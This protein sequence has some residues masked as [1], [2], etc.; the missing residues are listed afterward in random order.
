MATK[1]R[2]KRL[3]NFSLK[4]IHDVTLQDFHSFLQIFSCLPLKVNRQFNTIWFY[5]SLRKNFFYFVFIS[6]VF[7]FFS[8]INILSTGIFLLVFSLIACRYFD[9]CCKI[10]LSHRKN[11]RKFC[12]FLLFSRNYIR[13]R[14]TSLLNSRN[15]KYTN[16]DLKISVY[17]RV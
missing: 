14:R 3:G 2:S 6:T 16:G 5:G 17:V 13:T 8:I 9:F 4:T 11:N 12:G 15:L 1:F 7:L 10:I